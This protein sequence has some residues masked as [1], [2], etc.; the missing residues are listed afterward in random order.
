[1]IEERLRRAASEYG[2][3]PPAPAALA[4]SAPMPAVDQALGREQLA[5]ALATITRREIELCVDQQA[6]GL[7]S[8]RNGARLTGDARSLLDGLRGEGLAGYRRSA[9]RQDGA[10]WPMRLA[11]S[12][13]RRLGIQRPLAQRLADRFARLLVRREVL[14][15][16]AEFA[17]SRIA[18]LFGDRV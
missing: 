2:L 13:H 18:D 14:G 1:E 16:L 6:R 17:A 4:D 8:R 3:P 11:V 5:S 9:A 12:C 10:S 7:V 15:D